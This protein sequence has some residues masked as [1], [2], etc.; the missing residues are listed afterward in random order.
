[1]IKIMK[2]ILPLFTLLL[3]N[4]GNL[5]MYSLTPSLPV[6]S[7]A[8][9]F[10]MTSGEHFYVLS[11]VSTPIQDFYKKKVAIV[12]NEEEVPETYSKKIVEKSSSFLVL[13]HYNTP[14]TVKKLLAFSEFSPN[15][16][17]HNSSL[18]LLFKVFR[19]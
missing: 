11:K 14:K 17:S 12:D 7:V 6:S 13:S 1:M 9:S 16:P 5:A 8:E 10:Q 15:L 4:N 2:Y 19:I 3:F 18:Y